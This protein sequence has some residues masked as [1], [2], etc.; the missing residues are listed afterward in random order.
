MKCQLVFGKDKSESFTSEV[1]FELGGSPSYSGITF[2]ALNNELIKSVIE[3]KQ[4]LIFMI[5]ILQLI[6]RIGFK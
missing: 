3:S 4:N 6:K 2:C 1:G 5:S